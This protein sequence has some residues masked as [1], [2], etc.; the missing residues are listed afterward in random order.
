M[1]LVLASSMAMAA[2]MAPCGRALP[3]RPPPGQGAAR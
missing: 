2:A 1:A 3:R